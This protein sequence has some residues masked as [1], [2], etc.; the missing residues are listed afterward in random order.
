MNYGITAMTLEG[1]DPMQMFNARIIS[2]EVIGRMVD[3]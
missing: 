1:D 2:I 3:P